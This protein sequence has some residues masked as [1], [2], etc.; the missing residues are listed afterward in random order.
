MRLFFGVRKYRAL[1]RHGM[2]GRSSGGLLELERCNGERFRVLDGH[3]RVL[4][5]ADLM[6]VIGSGGDEAG[7]LQR[8]SGDTKRH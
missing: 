4:H 6:G 3:F 5:M 7:L 1:D 8:L 2:A